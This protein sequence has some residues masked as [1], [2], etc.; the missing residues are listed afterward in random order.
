MDKSL[1]PTGIFIMENEFWKPVLG[2]NND[3]FVSN[4][5]RV[6]SL[7]YGKER[8]ENRPVNYVNVV[9]GVKDGCNPEEGEYSFMITGF[10]GALDIHSIGGVDDISLIKDCI[11]NEEL[12]F[13]N[14]GELHIV[15]K[16]TGEW[17]D[18]FWNKYYVVDRICKIEH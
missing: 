18:V 5:G 15:L 7:K 17:E 6:K 13:P 8:I 3:Y 14:N 9:L 2:Y 16:E 12:D 10:L 11:E 1:C 4:M